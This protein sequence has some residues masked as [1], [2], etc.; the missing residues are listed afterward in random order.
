MSDLD[1]SYE[2]WAKQSFS[3]GST[4]RHFTFTV[5][6]FFVSCV[7]SQHGNTFTNSFSYNL[8]KPN[9]SIF[10]FFLKTSNVSANIS[11]ARNQIIN[12]NRKKKSSKCVY[13]YCNNIVMV[14]LIT[15]SER[16][17]KMILNF[18][19][20]SYVSIIADNTPDCSNIIVSSNKTVESG[21][22]CIK[23]YISNKM[24]IYHFK[25]VYF[26]NVVAVL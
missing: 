4:E 24:L 22:F 3:H 15:L 10:L 5:S 19:I 13:E 25:R 23:E 1:I 11:L 21:D 12:S 8:A 16:S 17:V 7:E 9:L 6:H 14:F 18:F 2:L 26:P 20:W